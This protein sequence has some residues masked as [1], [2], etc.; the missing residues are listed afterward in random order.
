MEFNIYSKGFKYHVYSNGKL[1]FSATQKQYFIFDKLFFYGLENKVFA[2][3]IDINFIPFILP[4]RIIFQDEEIVC[5]ISASL[6]H[7][8]LIY[9]DN[10]Y[11]IRNNCKKKV[12]GLYINHTL[13]GTHKVISDDSNHSEQIILCRHELGCK[14]FSIMAIALNLGPFEYNMSG[15]D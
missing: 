2:S 12:H 11:E 5:K 6:A 14:I 9:K 3:S 1:M 4:T 15:P 10:K 7:A 8:F 13:V